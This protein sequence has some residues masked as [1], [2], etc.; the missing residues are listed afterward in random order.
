MSALLK[1]TA[2]KCIIFTYFIYIEFYV[3]IQNL[4][5]MNIFNSNIKLVGLLVKYKA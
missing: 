5:V 4:K 1:N 2:Q 3:K